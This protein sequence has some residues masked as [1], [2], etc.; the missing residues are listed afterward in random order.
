LHVETPEG[1]PVDDAVIAV[2]GGMPEHNH[3][4]PTEPQVTEAL[5]NG[6]YRVEGMQFQMGGW[7]TITFVIDAAGQ[8]DS[9]TF[10]L[11]L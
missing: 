2:S 8:Q 3:G 5:G 10:N 7:W 4:M 11:K 6:D 9:V 1:A